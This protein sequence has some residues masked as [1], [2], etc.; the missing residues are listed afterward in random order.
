M[1]REE[2]I[3][4]IEQDIPCEH[5]TDLIEALEMAIKALEQEPFNIET[6]CK[7]HFVVMVDK[8]VWEKAEKALKQENILDEMFENIKTEIDFI[9]TYGAKFAD[10][11]IN[12][13]VNKKDVLQIIDKY[14]GEVDCHSCK[15]EHDCYECEKYTESEE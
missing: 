8:D 11:S 15:T 4:V 10:G 3:E 6:Y 13:H 5:D 14:R 9:P 1:T 7:E 12:V 2:A